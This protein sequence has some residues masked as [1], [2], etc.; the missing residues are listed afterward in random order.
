LYK[1]IWERYV[2]SQMAG[3]ILNVTTVEVKA[4]DC[5]FRASGSVIVFPGFMQVYIEGKDDKEG[6]DEGL[7]A[8]VQEG[9]KLDLKK[10]D[11]K[12]HFTQPAP[13]YTEAMLIKTLEELG[14]GRPSTYAPIIDT[15]LA[16]G[17]V[18]KEE[19]QLYPTELGQVVVDVMKE[20]FASII[21]VEFTA[22]MEEK[23]DKVEEGDIGWREVLEEF[24]D[25][26]AQ[27]LEHAEKEM[28]K[29]TIVPEESGDMCEKCGK[30]MVYRMGRFGRFLACSG[31]PECR[32][33]KPIIKITDIKCLA[34]GGNIIER[35]SRTGR[36]FYGC[37]HYPECKYV[38]WDLPIEEKC[39]SCGTQLATKTMRSGNK[40]NVCP[41]RDCPAN[42]K[43]AKPKK[44]PAAK[45]KPKS[46]AK[47]K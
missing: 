38:S 7:I 5:I 43:E 40:I 20:F 17:Y 16:R 34:C 33:T 36:I 26:F 9:E 15:I 23:L 11:P 32:N 42:I 12:Q 39:L 8:P 35:K 4:D 25:P 31:F 19:K 44:A 29:I 22:G 18:V 30:P 10:L 13:R 37:D 6:S 41:N 46:K 14:I 24:Y 1:L 21:D 27:M 28:E 45:A 3:A 2:A 47:K